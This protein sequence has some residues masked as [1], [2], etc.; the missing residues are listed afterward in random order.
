MT[1]RLHIT[2]GTK[3]RITRGVSIGKWSEPIGAPS[4]VYG[5]EVAWLEKG[6]ILTAHLHCMY[7]RLASTSEAQWFRSGLESWH[8]LTLSPGQTL[9]EPLQDYGPMGALVVD[10]P[11]GEDVC[12]DA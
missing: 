10:D 9:L 7:Q 3:H 12:A 4:S 1:T 8:V 6:T 5:W 2:P 11:S